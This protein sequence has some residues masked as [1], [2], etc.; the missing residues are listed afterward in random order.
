MSTTRVAASEHPYRTAT[1]GRIVCGINGS[2]A[3]AEA[4]RQ[5]AVLSGSEGKLEIVCVIGT[6]GFGPTA[7]ASIAPTRAETAMDHAELEVK[8]LGVHPRTCIVQGSSPWRSLARFAGE[9][10][11]LVLGSRGGSRAGGIAL[12]SVATEA[13]HRASL[14]ILIARPGA[15]TFPA[16]ILLASDGSPGSREA[17]E[18]AIRIARVHRSS[19]TLLTAGDVDAGQRRELALQAAEIGQATGKEP[20]VVTSGES[21]RA[22]IVRHA[23]TERPSLVVLGSSGKSGVRALGSVGEHIAHEVSSSVLVARGRARD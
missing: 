7:Q 5:A 16:S 18:L 2:R 15:D 1:F 22:A 3:D 11:L 17:A 10:D 14:P 23:E 9:A 12:G 19:V 21:P 4:V 8:E 20:L 13:V 6:M